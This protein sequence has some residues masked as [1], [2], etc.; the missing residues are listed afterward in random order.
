MG[1]TFERVM[2]SQPLEWTGERLT[3]AIGGQVEVEHLHR[4]FLARDLCLDMDVLDVASGE[5]YGS[6][7]L[8]QSARSVLGIDLSVVSVAHANASYRASNLRFVVADA[9]SIPLPNACVDMV[10]SFE[11]IEH[12]AEHDRFLHEVRRVLRPG[13]RFVVSTPESDVY[14]PSDAQP[15]PYHV[16]ELTRTEFV[17]LLSGTFKH[18]VL[19]AQRPIAGSAL[20]A[21][22][23]SEAVGTILTFERREPTRFESSE[24]LPRPMYLIAH[25]SDAP[26]THFPDSLYIDASAINEA[27][28]YAR[29]LE[30]ELRASNGALAAASAY[31]RRLEV[32]WQTTNAALQRALVERRQLV[33]RL[34]A[35]LSSTSWRITRP[36]RVT[37]RII[38][39]AATSLPIMGRASQTR[40][41]DLELSD[42]LSRAETTFLVQADAELADIKADLTIQAKAELASFLASNSRLGFFDGKTPEISVLIVLWN[43]SHLTLRCL[44][45]LDKERSAAA[46]SFELL[47]VDNASW[48]ETAELLSRLDGARVIRNTQNDGF[49]RACNQAAAIARGS[50]LLF[51][52]NDAFIR[53]GALSAAHA[54]LRRDP[55]IGAVGGRLILPSG[56]LQEAG[57]IVWSDGSTVGYGRGS[58]ADSGEAMFRR[59]VDY[60][61]GAFLM[62]PR[63]VWEKLG[64]FDK[65]Y[66]PAYYEDADYCMRVWEA[67]LRV[68]YEPAAAI[69]HCEFGSS[70][71]YGETFA[72]QLINR[73]HFRARHAE[74]LRSI[75]LPAAE[76]NVLAA[77]E[78]RVP[79]RRRLLVLDNE[80]PLGALGSGYPRMR[81]MLVQAM[82]AGWSTSF[83]PMHN[84]DVAWAAARA[85]IPWG[86][87]ILSDRKAAN[88]SE[89]LEQRYGHYDLILVSRPDNMALLREVLRERP[90]LIHGTRLIYDAEA[91]FAIRTST[92]AELEGHPLPS[93]EID[94][95]V[96]DEIDLAEDAD[97]IVCVTE[98]EAQKFRDRH[99]GS[100]HV[101]GHPTKPRFNAPGFEY[102]RGFLFVGRLLEKSAPNWR[103]LSWFI[104]EVWPL[105]R[106]KLPNA[107]LIVAGYLNLDCSDLQAPGVR[108][109][110]PVVDLNPIYDATRVFVAPVQ[111]AAGLPIKI[112][113]A[114]AAGL[115]T[116]A[117]KLMAQQLGWTPGVEIAA[118]DDPGALAAAAA[119]LHEES[120]V[121]SAMRAAAQL[122]IAREHTAE[123]FGSR[124]RALLDGELPPSDGG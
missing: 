122:R 60:C 29:K 81:E 21:E 28:S 93:E 119:T 114:T 50:T 45:A 54:A 92:E 117:T 15:N 103:G 17:R 19:K 22:Q 11:T 74:R 35:T 41:R 52:N 83:F 124:L 3:T 78:H 94:R 65:I 87:E 37:R 115:P 79:G 44:Q 123:A 31:A 42:G 96:N 71:T 27:A 49:V 38:Q 89:F 40:Q 1:E 59:D 24:G 70:T 33:G 20:I 116:A 105:I 100:V 69:D 118:D 61:S 88:L 58:A 6:A 8:A 55:D 85:E 12:F 13:G 32:D 25:A 80:V 47:I 53:M 109:V 107:E 75:H 86:I 62:T 99:P 90:H 64:G 82:A 95:I 73:K 34:D 104:R 67:G 36:L 48:D 108:L 68:V 66:A 5:G 101:L 23:T 106:G 102:R 4:Y 97:A 121:W 120:S 2:P 110:G 26:V 72:T 14:S 30:A 112:L 76:I 113:E 39:R 9:R 7:F 46:P 77:R 57:S 51:L 63:V 98:A 18:V 16:R 43:Q 56:Q 84:P 91:L 10:V 111:F